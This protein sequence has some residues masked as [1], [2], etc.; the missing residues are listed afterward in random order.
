MAS[1]N[2]SSKSATKN[3]TK[4]NDVQISLAKNLVSHKDDGLAASNWSG[5]GKFPTRTFQTLEKNGLAKPKEKKNE[6]G[7]KETFWFPTA[8]TA[9][10]V[11]ARG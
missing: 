6:S 10:A 3:T 5:D 8:K 7:K 1:K 11:E 4:L 9:K 2:G